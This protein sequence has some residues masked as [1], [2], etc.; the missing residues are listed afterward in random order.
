VTT[1]PFF[2]Q[3][4][5]DFDAPYF[6][7]SGPREP[8]NLALPVSLD[9]RAF[10]VDTRP[11]T[12]QTRFQ[13]E[14]VQ[15]LHTQ[16][17]D[18][19]GDQT[20][21]PP[22]MWRRIVE[23]WHFGQGQTRYDRVNSLPYRFKSSEGIN[24]WDEWGMSLLKETQNIRALAAGASMLVSLNVDTLWV[25]VGSTGYWWS[26]LSA[27]PFPPAAPTTMSMGAAVV[28]ATTDGKNL[29]TLS[30]A[31]VVKKWTDATTST[32][33]ATVTTFQPTKA[34]IRYI[35]GFL[36]VGN[37]NR[38]VDVT[39]GAPLVVFTHPLVDF[40]WVD[41]C[42]GL[43]NGF[44]LGG[45]GDRWLIQSITVS[46][47]GLT[48]APP[49]VAAPLPEGEVGYALGAYLA[50]VVVGTS[51]GWHFAVPGGDGQ[52]QVGRLV[53][54]DLPVR[55]FEGQDR[56]VWFGQSATTGASGLGRADLSTFIQPMTPASASDLAA[57]DVG[58]VRGVTT[59]GAG[60]GGLGRRVFTVDGVGVFMEG[61]NLVPIGTLNQ[62]VMTFGTSDPKMGLYAQLYSEP[63]HGGIQVD[64]SWD[65]GPQEVVA[66]ATAQDSLSAGNIPAARRFAS[67]SFIFTLTRATEDHTEG[68]RLTRLEF[69]AIPVTGRA[70]EWRVPL[71]VHD[72]IT[73]DNVSAGRDVISDF[74]MLMELVESRREFDYREGTRLYR[75]HAV[76]FLW[77]PHHLTY[78][79]D[80]YNG[81]YLI[82][83]REIR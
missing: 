12:G 40:Y 24:V 80:A 11:E 55:C 28:S 63:L 69:R 42:E 46:N 31:G 65:F 54:T 9:G 56:F 26:G 72:D 3:V 52:L 81:T 66:E 13:R 38:L 45:M 35:K 36:L 34:V 25:G 5:Q 15:L 17:Q 27:G 16:Q 71:L 10:L 4:T 77:V 33:F 58:I 61:D 18:S 14:S 32:T 64:V 39:T 37:G 8:D 7:G 62:G 23:S 41:M 60:A 78:D 47:D 70:S 29:Y 59:V 21:V 6:E 20:L 51:A 49:I 1:E 57:D 73:Y 83:L 82:V 68:P 48:L 44:L 43:S 53:N 50:Y 22:E 19:S 76:D 74:D 75:V 30:D 2:Q 67:A 79:G